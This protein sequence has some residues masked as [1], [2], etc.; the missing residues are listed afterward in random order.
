MAQSPYER[1]TDQFS[2]FQDE[3]TLQVSNMTEQAR[4]AANRL[5]AQAR[6]AGVGMQEVAGN[7]K[8]ALDKSLQDQP[9]A[10]LA[11]AAIAGFFLG[12]IWKA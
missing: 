4:G 9:V 3:A 1:T 8:S 2:N 5:D 7:M 10:T 6:G 12:A 11:L